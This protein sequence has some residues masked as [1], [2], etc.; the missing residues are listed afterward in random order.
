MVDG[1]RAAKIDDRASGD[2]YAIG[3]A[4]YTAFGGALARYDGTSRVALGNGTRICS[5]SALVACG[6]GACVLDHNC[7]QVIQLAKSGKVI[8]TL[9]E[10]QLFPARPWSL[11]GA[12]AR[13]DGA[14]LVEAIHRDQTRGKEI[15]ETAIYE[16]PAALF[17]L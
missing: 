16:L 4:L 6:D 1:R 7:M 12:V 14:V 15:C 2:L 9:D 8:R 3:G 13:G 5:S 11:S 10:R 17:A